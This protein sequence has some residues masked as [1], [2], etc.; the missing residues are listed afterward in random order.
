[1][2]KILAMPEG[3]QKEESKQ[4]LIQVIQSMVQQHSYTLLQKVSQPLYLQTP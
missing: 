2:Q 3:L 4:G 1:V